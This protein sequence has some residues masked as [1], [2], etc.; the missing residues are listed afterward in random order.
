MQL[1]N[2]L[3]LR[4]ILKEQKRQ[5]IERLSQERQVRLI[6]FIMFLTSLLVVGS[7]LKT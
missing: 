7:I 4:A 5:K 1:N 3:Q 2:Q 6:T